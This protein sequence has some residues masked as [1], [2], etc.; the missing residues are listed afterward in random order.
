MICPRV[1]WVSGD[2]IFVSAA[3]K[4]IHLPIQETREVWVWS[5]EFRKILKEVATSQWASCTEG[6]T[7][8]RHQA[9]L[10]QQVYR[11]RGNW[12]AFCSHLD[13]CMYMYVCAMFSLLGPEHAGTKIFSLTNG[14]L[15]RS[16]CLPVHSR[17]RI[18]MAS[19]SQP[20]VLKGENFRDDWRGGSCTV[21]GHRKPKSC[22]GE[23]CGVVIA[24]SQITRHIKRDR[25]ATPLIRALD[26]LGVSFNF[27]LWKWVVPN[28]EGV[29]LIIMLLATQWGWWQSIG[30]W[31]TDIL[32]RS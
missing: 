12:P 16:L 13:L 25:R 14:S 3:D 26:L 22:H 2:K 18:K 5:Y 11:V 7:D 21:L 19:E 4:E 15:F 17:A 23:T 30:H 8:R 32:E 10:I 27:H 20:G 24:L 1:T 29:C 6:S 31:E 28:P 9:G